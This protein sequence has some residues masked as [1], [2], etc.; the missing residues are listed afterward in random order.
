MSGEFMGEW[1][2][3]SLMVTTLLMGAILLLRRPV[4]QL[5]GPGVAYALWLIPAARL[6]MPSLEGDAVPVGQTGHGVSDAV[7]ESILAGVSSPD[8]V[9]DTA[10]KSVVAAVDLT[11]LGVTLWL[12]GAALFFIIQM[13]RYASMRDD[14]L[15]EAE[16]IASIEGVSVVAS[17]QVAGPLAFGLFKRYIA[18]PQDFTKTYSPAERELAIAHEMAHH[19]SGDLFANLLAFIILC[20]QWFNPVAWMSWNAFRFD[21]EAACDAR[22]LAGKGAEE[23]AIY[24]QALAR[25][26]FDG[27]PTFATALNS[28]KTIIE[29]LRR[30]TMKDASTKRRIFGKLGVIAAAAIILPL[31]AT[32][33]PAVVA[34]DEAATEGKPETVK[35]NVRVIKLKRDGKTVDI[36]GH[37]GDGKE[38]TKIERDGKIFIF[39][40]DKKLSQE[41]VEKMVDEAQ[42]SSEQADEA[43]V[44]ANEARSE[45]EAARG[46][47]EAA[48][49]EADVARAEAAA[50][51]GHAEAMRVHAVA[52]AAN[53]IP[54]IDIREI[55]KNCK[56]G[57]PVTTNVEGF[58]G[59]N[60]SR[61]R[62][63][64][65]G[66][67]QA[68]IAR[69]E[70]VKGLR[71]A[72]GEI[73]SEKEMPEAV[74]KDV[75]EKLEKEIRKLEAQADKAE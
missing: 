35:H 11:A 38:V 24:G 70:A 12:G 47:A 51:R 28:P 67:G 5:F 13:I 32:V 2:F 21:Q 55:T 29:R 48:R 56:E 43:L 64:M 19:K 31:T 4:A 62:L 22:V 73:A 18:V 15:S 20:L 63:V 33:V 57:Q 41:E 7:R 53:Y 60:K 45:A 58:D 30:L 66:K 9:V 74:R 40:T 1:L 72:R 65:C 52:M 36:V 71:E 34:Q 10:S 23:R 49:G 37:D 59:T 3:D 8:T 39:R 44:W 50:M 25:T 14:L 75:I 27:V 17:D 26:A 42:I 16:E 68:R 54:E 46:E 6:L 69:A 61:I